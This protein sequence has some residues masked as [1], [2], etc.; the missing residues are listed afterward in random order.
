LGRL[1][2]ELAKVVATPGSNGMRT[3]RLADLQEQL[4]AAEVRAVDLRT[5]LAELAA[6]AVDTQDLERVLKAFDPVWSALSNYQ[7]LL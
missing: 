6:K 3:D 7:N 1:Q 4:R 5:E 2:R